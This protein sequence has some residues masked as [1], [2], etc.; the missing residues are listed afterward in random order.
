MITIILNK[1]KN[2]TPIIFNTVFI[3][4]I[5]MTMLNNNK[6]WIDIIIANSCFICAALIQWSLNDTNKQQEIVEMEKL[7]EET[8]TKIN[9]EL[10]N[11]NGMSKLTS[12]TERLKDANIL[13]NCLQNLKRIHIEA[14][15]QI[16]EK[17]KTSSNLSLIEI[18]KFLGNNYYKLITFDKFM[19]L[20]CLFDRKDNDKIFEINYDLDILLDNLIRILL[21]NKETF[22]KYQNIEDI[23][24]HIKNISE[25]EFAEIMNIK[26]DGKDDYEFYKKLKIEPSKLDYKA[27]VDN[28][29]H[30][31]NFYI[32]AM[33]NIKHDNFFLTIKRIIH[34]FIYK[35]KM[36]F[37]I[38]EISLKKFLEKQ[39]CNK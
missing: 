16:R 20:H 30:D 17:D 18:E 1:L 37:L 23:F 25:K 5:T 26:N 3:I 35:I 28:G 6:S 2:F 36:Y 24:S 12:D 33:E 11:L 31:N 14:I 27:Y 4:T 32:F 39:K 10:N 19:Q 34:Q 29:K 13:Y 15:K 8:T 21:S 7:I 9:N 22:T 38:K